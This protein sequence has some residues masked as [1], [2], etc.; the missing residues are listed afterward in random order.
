MSDEDTP[1]APGQPD[2]P[3]EPAAD[4]QS[5]AAGPVTAAPDSATS[6][7]D[8]SDVTNHDEPNTGHPDD[9]DDD[10]DDEDAED[11]S[12]TRGNRTISPKEL[13]LVQGYGV[14]RNR[15]GASTAFG[16]GAIAVDTINYYG[17]WEQPSRKVRRAKVSAERISALR[18][19]YVPTPS[20]PRLAAA[21][22]RQSVV[23]MAGK[24]GTGQETS[25]HKAL[26]ERYGE[27][28][29][30]MS[31][32]DVSTWADAVNAVGEAL[33]E[34]HGYL[35]W[36][37][38]GLSIS[39]GALADL[40]WTAADHHT[41]I[42]LLGD[43]S[44]DER[45]TL[46]QYAVHHESPQLAEVFRRHLR[47]KL[48]GR[49]RAECVD[50]DGT[51]PDRSV[52]EYLTE[53]SVQDELRRLSFPREAVEAAQFIFDDKP[54]SSEAGSLLQQLA[55]NR[56]RRQAAVVLHP[57]DA[58]EHPHRERL[59]QHSRA[60]R[61][62]YALFHDL[63]LGN[64]FDAAKE[65]LPLLDKAR[66]WQYDE[67]PTYDMPIAQLLGPDLGHPGPQIASEGTGYV[68]CLSDERLMPSIV[69]VLWNDYG[70]FREPLCTWL[71]TLV[72]KGTWPIRQRAAT[73]AG[74]LAGYDFDQVNSRLIARWARS[75][76]AFERQVAAYAMEVATGYNDAATERVQKEIR[77]WAAPSSPK[78]QRDTAARCYATGY[79]RRSPEDA[80]RD[81]KSIAE[82]RM[83]LSR[84]VIADA[85]VGLAHSYP[86][87][88]V[89]VALA[90]WLD[91]LSSPV[92]SHAVRAFGRLADRCD[93]D[94]IPTL[95]RL[96]IDGAI[97]KFQLAMMWSHA[98]E[99]PATAKPAWPAL[100]QWISALDSEGQVQPGDDIVRDLLAEV[101]SHPAL[102]RRG[103]FHLAY[104][105]PS[106]TQVGFRWFA[107]VLEEG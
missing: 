102:R 86:I 103:L 37:P 7:A 6:S 73:I 3:D 81:L 2:N 96:F 80:L 40:Q 67:H 93:D 75:G 107:K 99:R 54:P 59:V 105:W 23:F 26:F 5:G 49:C 38:S 20:D 76:K 78:R 62:C 1:E 19:T 79:G 8:T 45:A 29:A 34:Q 98:L 91:P 32:G 14:D 100:E 51:C 31:L 88:K 87:E 83:Q 57:P 55:A 94:G 60:F 42:V 39:P 64:A 58:P 69:D 52:A 17:A 35:L 72:R 33:E 18:A 85:V 25:V 47:H 63:A 30:A 12:Y 9:D 15:F 46:H 13:R 82:D 106:P 36:L 65:L 44:P 10:D 21:L 70:G 56:V 53:P 24:A 16:S 104:V 43:V 11:D 77:G 84:S 89:F 74:V 68:A 92:A 90:T 4:E 71:E 50:C 22:G 28:M 66:G 48:L 95:M 61:I 97:D 101:F 27:Q 41:T